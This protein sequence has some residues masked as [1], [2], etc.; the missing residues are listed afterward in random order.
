MRRDFGMLRGPEIIARNAGATVA[1][2][3]RWI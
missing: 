2:L 1:D 3:I